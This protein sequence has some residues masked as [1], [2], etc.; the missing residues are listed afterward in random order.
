[1]SLFEELKRRNVFRAGA[2][3]VVAAWLI[4]QVVE[5]I[6]P[7]FGF[8]DA[9]IRL[10]VIVLAIGFLPAVILAWAFELTPQGLV[11]DSEVD[12]AAPEFRRLDK[13]LDRLIIAGLV[14][15]LAYFAVDKFVLAPRQMAEELEAAREQVRSEVESATAAKPSIAVL[16][17]D[18]LSP[19]GDQEYFSD[20]IAEELLNLLAKIPELRVISR[21]SAFAFKGKDMTIPAIAAQLNVAHILE[22]SV[23]KSGNRIRITAQLI[24]TTSDAHLWSETYD[25]TLDDVFAIQDEISAAIVEQLKIA[26]LGELPTADRID[27]DHYAL[28]LEAR[29]KWEQGGEENL[30]AAAGLI[31]RLLELEPAFARGWVLSSQ[32]QR[33]RLDYEY[34]ARDTAMEHLRRALELEPDL[35]SANALMAMIILFSGDDYARVAQRLER[36]LALDP[37]DPDVLRVATFFSQVLGRDELLLE[38][39]RLQVT[40][41]PLCAFCNYALTYAYL[42]LEM[43]DEAE[44]TI[45]RFMAVGRGGHYSLGYILLRKGAFEAATASFENPDSNPFDR[46]FG[47]LLVRLYRGAEQGIEQDIETFAE[48]WG[49][50]W[51][52]WVARLHAL[53]GDTEAAFEWLSAD[54]LQ[55]QSIW[56][57]LDLR[58]PDLESLHADPR[59]TTT[60]ERHR[61]APAQLE[62][63]AFAPDLPGN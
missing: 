63:I 23:R 36:A 34:P 33:S 10:V 43:L 25:R 52:I 27:P 16:A 40:R 58:S 19:A 18:D 50:D 29:F 57:L 13:R 55:G 21:S 45:R 24:D 3:Y 41:N 28:F 1:V 32:I 7:A 46:D 61:L 48:A 31:D 9:A 62:P 8:G 26:L 47:R 53:N 22:G 51:L 54:R 15:A 2:A 39:G 17:F 44:A 59:W 30:I 37:Y 12:R 42:A 5:T 49:S 4:I 60:L 56:V 14:L 11:A 20:G 35:P 38:L 6:F